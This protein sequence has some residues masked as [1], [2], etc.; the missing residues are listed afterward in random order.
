MRDSAAVIIT[1]GA[2]GSSI[3]LPDGQ[4][5][6]P[7]VPEERV[8]DPTGVG[9]A[10]RGGLMKGMA[11]GADW[12]TCGRMGSVAATYALEHVGGM[13]HSYTWTDF[14]RRYE[15]NFGPLKI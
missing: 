7:A 13:S 8:V 15:V 12:E 14:K 9:D 2:A 11:V 5:D 3:Y 1:K 10:F 6:V 4:I